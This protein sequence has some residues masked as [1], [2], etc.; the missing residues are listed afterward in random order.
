[1]FRPA[2][3]ARVAACTFAFALGVMPARAGAPQQGQAAASAKKEFAFHGLVKEIDVKGKRL[4]V[5]GENVPGWMAAMTMMYAVDNGDM[6]SK[7][8]T[9][10]RISAKVREG[11]FQKLYEVKISTMVAQPKPAAKATP[12]APTVKKN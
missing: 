9:G 8:R 4:T 10:D 6:V 2:I 5:D 1:M 7:L 11:D 12:T 3:A